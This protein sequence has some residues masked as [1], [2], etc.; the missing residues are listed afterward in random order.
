MDL[1]FQVQT[2]IQKPVSEVFE[3]VYNPKKLSAYFTT[4][5]SDGSLDEGR[6]VLWTFND[7]GDNPVTVPVKVRK[8]VPNKLIQF[9]W[10]ASEGTYDPKTGS[11]PRPGGYDNTVEMSFEA[12][13]E[14][15]TL[16]RIVEGSWRS[17]QD[18]LQGSYGN[19]SGWMN[20]SCCLK[21]FLEYGINLRKGAF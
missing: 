21:A 16:V 3:A 12:L 13:G 18:G 10:A 4:G 15:E 11:M 20:M 6:T 14:N 7:H 1:K 9:L 17:T 8:M 19:C 5:G 2:K